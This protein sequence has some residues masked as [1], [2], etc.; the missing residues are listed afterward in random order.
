MRRRNYRRPAAPTQNLDSFLDILTNTVGVLM[1]IGLFVSLFNVETQAVIRTPLV[2][3]TQKVP[4]F[5]EVR[6]DR[7]IYLDKAAVDQRIKK[8]SA[9]MPPCE[10]PEPPSVFNS[11]LYQY[12]LSQLRSYQVCLNQQSQQLRTFRTATS[13]YDVYF[14]PYSSGLV[15][16]PLE[17]EAGETTKELTAANS[18]Y[19]TV[20]QTLDPQT[21]YLAFIVRPDSFKAFREA[22]GVAWEKNFDVG[23]EP[24]REDAA[25]SFGSGG[26]S[27]GVQ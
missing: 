1:F 21:D 15:F 20:L 22:R 19:R 10:E 8:F 26:R 25:I 14:D 12:Y 17:A 23:W 24:M 7:V 9:S 3:Q 11:A 13:N 2:S 6:G 27:I 16:E 5:F 4:H 18:D